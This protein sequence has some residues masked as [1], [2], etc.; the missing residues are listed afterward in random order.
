[1]PPATDPPA[2]DDPRVAEVIA[3]QRSELRRRRAWILATR[4]T[5]LALAAW[6][7]EM[8]I[9]EGKD[10]PFYITVNLVAIV[11]GVSV[12]VVFNYYDPP[13]V[14]RHLH[15]PDG[16][17]R[18]ASV[19]ALESLR[20]QVLPPLLQD[21]GVPEPERGRLVASITADELVR[22]TA[23]RMHGDRKKFGRIYLAI[24]VPLLLG[25][26]AL[27]ATYQAGP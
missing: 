12:L 11:V 27:V 6:Y 2:A 3:A 21:L 5:S 24:L 13:L 17:L 8:I 7:L 4:C 23:T 10:A 14:V 16:P 26:I 18:R 19:V 9:R 1:M 20:D 15:G 25:F 22:R